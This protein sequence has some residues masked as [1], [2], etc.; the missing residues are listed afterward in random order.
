LIETWILVFL[1]SW[2]KK[3]NIKLIFYDWPIYFPLICLIGYIVFEVMIF[4][5]QYWITQYGTII[6]PVTLLS[7]F[8]LMYK[9]N[10]YYSQNKSKSELVRFLISPFIIGIIFLV[11]GYIF[12]GIAILS[13]NG[14]MPVFPSY[15]YFTN[16]TDISSFTEDS[17]YILG[18]HTSKA[19]W[20]CDCIDIFYSNLSLGDVFV[21]IYVAILIYFSI[22]RVNEKHKININV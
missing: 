6:K 9:Y 15:T 22:K 11:L 21:R 3:L 20:A 5:D 18:D 17:F 14:H 19:I 16:Y 7:Y 4:N 8:G 2:K 1:Y 13:N 10:L 12:N